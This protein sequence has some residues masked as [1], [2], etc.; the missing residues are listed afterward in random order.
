[1]A[2]LTP[3]LD[4]PPPD[5][6]VLLRGTPLP[7]AALGTPIPVTPGDVSVVLAAPAHPNRRAPSKEAGDFSV[8][9]TRHWASP[10]REPPRPHC[11]SSSARMKP[12]SR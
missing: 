12:P 10:V 9:P 11:S 5:T 6:R 1:M 7:R 2:R 3:R 4:A 8:S